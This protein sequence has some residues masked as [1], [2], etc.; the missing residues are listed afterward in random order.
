MRIL[1]LLTLLFVLLGIA[2]AC[3]TPATPPATGCSRLA[4]GLDYCPPGPQQP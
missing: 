2:N 3:R 4:S 1:W